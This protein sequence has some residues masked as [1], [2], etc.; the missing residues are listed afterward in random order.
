MT[1]YDIYLDIVDIKEKYDIIYMHQK[2]L[3]V[4]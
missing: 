2:S 3:K 1:I 4:L